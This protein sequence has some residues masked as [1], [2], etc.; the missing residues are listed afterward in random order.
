MGS[1][2][3]LQKVNKDIII[4]SLFSTRDFAL[5]N[6]NVLK[7]VQRLFPNLGFVNI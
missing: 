1:E 4:L 6:K 2:Y 3:K 7:I 5:H